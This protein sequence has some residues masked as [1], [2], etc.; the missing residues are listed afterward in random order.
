MCCEVMVKRDGQEITCETVG[1]LAKA[2]GKQ[3]IFISPFPDPQ[4]CLCSARLEELGARRATE[5]EGWPWPEY[6]IEV[7]PEQRLLI[8]TA[9]PVA[10]QDSLF[11]IEAPRKDRG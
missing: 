11:P 9:P 8:D 10:T 3:P 5:E 6:I 2:L 4:S 7:L 1:E